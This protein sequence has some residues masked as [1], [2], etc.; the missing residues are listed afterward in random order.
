MDSPKPI[1]RRPEFGPP[2]RVVTA[3][4]TLQSTRPRDAHDLVEILYN[5]PD[6]RIVAFSATGKTP[7][8]DSR[9]ASSTPDTEDPGSLTPS[10]QLERTIAF[11]E[12]TSLTHI[13]P[14]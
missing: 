10:S 7:L 8:R 5:H 6:V 14:A 3:P 1:P 13:Q 2:R 11:G 4:M 9:A 12:K